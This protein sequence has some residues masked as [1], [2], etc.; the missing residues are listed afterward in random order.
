MVKL[1]CGLILCGM[2]KNVFYMDQGQQG[3]NQ[4]DEAGTFGCHLICKTKWCIQLETVGRRE[5]ME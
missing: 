1:H 3:E 2:E 4:V 5:K